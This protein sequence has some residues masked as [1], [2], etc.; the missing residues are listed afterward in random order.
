[1][2]FLN[3]LQTIIIMEISG[4]TNKSGIIKSH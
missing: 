2:L 4:T 3:L 1:L